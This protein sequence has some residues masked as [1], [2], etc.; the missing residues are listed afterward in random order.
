MF[1]LI[2]LF[3]FPYLLTFHFFYKKK[4][5]Q[6]P[7]QQEQ[8]EQSESV[9]MHKYDENWSGSNGELACG[10]SGWII[11]ASPEGKMYWHHVGTETSVWEEPKAAR[12]YKEATEINGWTIHPSPDGEPYWYNEGSGESVW[13]EPPEMLSARLE[14]LEKTAPPLT[15]Q[16]QILFV[17]R[18]EIQR[19]HGDMAELR[20]HAAKNQEVDD[21]E[22]GDADWAGPNKELACGRSGWTIHASPEGKMFWHHAGDENSLWEEPEECAEYRN[23]TE[24]DGW[25]VHPSPDGLPYW[26]NERTLESVWVEPE[27]MREAREN[28]NENFKSI[29][30]IAAEEIFEKIVELEQEVRQI[31][32]SDPAYHLI[33]A[34]KSLVGKV[35]NQTIHRDDALQIARDR[36]FDTKTDFETMANEGRITFFVFLCSTG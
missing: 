11:H 7:E 32:A 22:E 17:K 1:L 36:I 2:F 20:I 24:V 29:E 12:I 21:A 27:V 14:Y 5:D 25:S 3:F 31:L 4:K 30:T 28:C 19:L 23:E 34:R 9:L 35:G 33:Q 10:R 26:H 6:Q 18:V 13:D 15:P 16:G 8:L